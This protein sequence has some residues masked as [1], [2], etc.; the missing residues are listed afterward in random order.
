MKIDVV[1]IRLVKEREIDYDKPM[2]KPLDTVNFVL[3][4]MQDLDREMC[5]TL[6]LDA[7]QC[8]L[9]AHVVSVGGLDGT[10][11]D[12]KSVM[13]SALLSNAHG[14]IMY[15]NHPSGNS[16]PSREDF[17]ITEK[18]QRACEVMDIQFLDHIIIGRE[19]YYSIKGEYTR[20]YDTSKRKGK[21]EKT[22]RVLTIQSS[23]LDVSKK[24][25]ANKDRCNYQEALPV[26]RR[27]FDDYNR[28]KETNYPSFFWGFS[29]LKTK[30]MNEAIER[31]SEMIGE[32][33]G[34]SKIYVLDIPSELC[35]ETDFYNFADEIYAYQYPNEMESVWNSIYE[36]RNSERQVIFPYIEPSM[37]V[38]EIKQGKFIEY[39]HEEHDLELDEIE[40]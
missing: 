40:K 39:D 2:Q 35:L 38:G 20:P 33:I 12:I 7:K 21:S 1:G 36:K 16:T 25:F 11:V 28:M 37:I 14:I 8:V 27:L 13:K 3:E 23:D 15:H 31:A 22:I 29:K 18:I 24:E 30:D 34:N 5:M 6:N 4:E 9:N 17:L 26:Y 32:E 10:I 19:N